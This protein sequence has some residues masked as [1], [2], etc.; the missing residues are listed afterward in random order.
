MIG[1][2]NEPGEECFN[3]TVCTPKSLYKCLSEKSFV[4]G[5]HHLII[6]YYNYDIIWKA[7][8]SICERISGT[9]WKE[10]AEKLS[11]YGQWEFED[12]KGYQEQ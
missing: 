8:N 4:F 11:R 1:A 9:S 10:V 3:F 2:K 7:I 12:Y 6:S 5:K